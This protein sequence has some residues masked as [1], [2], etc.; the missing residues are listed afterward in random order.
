MGKTGFTDIV[1]LAGGFG[2]RLWP[3]SIPEFPKQF[4]ALEDGISFIQTAIMRALDV[5]PS[6]KILVVSRPEICGE[7]TRQVENLKPVLSSS[8]REKISN[9]LYVIAEP[10]PRHTCP[11]LLLA[12]K[13]LELSSKSEHLILVLTSDHVIGPMENFVRD[14]HKA[15][16]FVAQGNFVC[17]AI[18]PAE[19]STGFGYIK[20]GIP[21]DAEESVFKIDSFKEKPD[22]E[23]ARAY[24]A[25]G[26]YAWNSGMF[27]FS[28]SLFEDEIKKYEPEMHEAFKV[29]DT[30]K[31]PECKILNSIKYIEGW[32]PLVDSYSKTKA[33]AVD[34]A[35]AER[36]DRAVAVKA[37]FDWDDVGSWDSFEKYFKKDS[38]DFISVE[39]SGNFVY[40]DMPV[41]LCGVQD[42]IVVVKNGKILVMKKGAS[43]SMR[44]VVKKFKEKN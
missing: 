11:P 32:E 37:S 29:F 6:G 43:S 2:D 38:G 16:E 28:A 12:C 23:T 30:A 13:F 42:L 5:E 34:N 24:L 17:F 8:H 7:L 35:V 41:A 19:P 10:C 9:D 21:L 36:T 33:V 18:P 20:T 14:C 22:L 15:A 3:A 44:E 26:K 31:L 39:S 1:I 40:S 25:T 27:G 4:M